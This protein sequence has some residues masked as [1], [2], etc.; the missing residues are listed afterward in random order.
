MAGKQALT[1]PDC[2]KLM[3]SDLAKA[4]A[5]MKRLYGYGNNVTCPCARNVLV[6][7]VYNLGERGLGKFKTFKGLILQ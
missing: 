4:R 7:M 3:K 6:D 5:G 1:K 2:D